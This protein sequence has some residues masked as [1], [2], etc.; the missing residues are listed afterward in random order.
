M[1]GRRSPR[2]AG[3][4]ALAALAVVAYLRR[5]GAARMALV[6]EAAHELRGPLGAA[7]LGL[8]GVVGD[9]A[10]CAARGRG[11]ARAAPRRRS[12]STTSTRRRA[13]AARRVR[14]AGRRAARCSPSAVEA[15]RPL[16]RALAVRAAL[17]P[18]GCRGSSSAPT[19]CGSPR[20]SGNLVANALEHGG[21]PVRVRAHATR[22]HVRIEVRDHGPGLPAPVAA[23]AAG[24]PHAGRRGH[25]LAIAGRVV[26]R[27]GG[28]LLTAPVSSGACVVL[29]LPR[30]DAA[31]AIRRRRAAPPVARAAPRS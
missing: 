13:G 2:P 19:R 23:L 27:H 12:R 17:R 29:E 31:R 16:A 15:W 11:R 30:A 3:A 9:A 28:R 8:H 20:P 4:S 21:G 14:R 25:G 5:H 1:T 6:A 7:L 26:R 18:A 24:A 22:G 10:G